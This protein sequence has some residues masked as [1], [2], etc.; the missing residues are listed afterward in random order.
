MIAIGQTGDNPGL[1]VKQSH[2]ADSICSP[3]AARIVMEGQP[4]ALLIDQTSLYRD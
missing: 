3:N 4:V 2:E 1:K